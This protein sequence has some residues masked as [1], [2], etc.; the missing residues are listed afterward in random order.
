MCF[1]VED[2]PRLHRAVEYG[3]RLLSL[4]DRFELIK[5]A[6]EQFRQAWRG[7]M[8]GGGVGKGL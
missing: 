7:R 4:L 2:G 6:R 8:G 5:A 1:S 3:P